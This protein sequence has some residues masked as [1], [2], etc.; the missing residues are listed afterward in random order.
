M[1][2]GRFIGD[3]I[4][5]IEGTFGYVAS[6]TQDGAFRPHFVSSGT[7]FLSQGAGEYFPFTVVDFKASIV[8]PTA[9]E[10]RPASVSAYVCIK[11]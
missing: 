8:V 3:A 9:L 2:I 6:G 10:N 5:N 4:R 1:S 11:Y 7:F